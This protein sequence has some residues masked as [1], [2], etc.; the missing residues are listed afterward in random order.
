MFVKQK[1]CEN[2]FQK[3][4]CDVESGQVTPRRSGD[5]VKRRNLMLLAVAYSASIGG[6]GV[7]TGT[8]SNLIILEVK[9][10]K[11]FSVFYFY[12]LTV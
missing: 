5:Y 1:T 9:I 8:P 3:E 6:T 11:T 10:V 7:I 4:T 2:K 12:S